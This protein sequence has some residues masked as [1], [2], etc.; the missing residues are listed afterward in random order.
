MLNKV[1]LNYLKQDENKNIFA[2]EDG[3]YKVS[4]FKKKNI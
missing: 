2:D 1:L 3:S 4:F